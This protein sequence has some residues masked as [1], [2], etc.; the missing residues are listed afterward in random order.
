M[1]ETRYTIDSKDRVRQWQ[2]WA[3]E[4]D[5]IPG[6]LYTDGLVDGKMKDPIF[7]AAKEK[8]V[9]KANYISPAE[10]AVLMV[11]Q[12]V[13]KKERSNYFSTPEEARENKL[14]LPMLCPSGMKWRD[15]A[16]N[17]KKVSWPA[18]ASPKLDGARCNIF[19][20][21]GEVYAQTRTGK[22]WLNCDHI[23]DA[24]RPLLEIHPNW[25]ID[26]E[27]YNHAFKDNFEDLMSIIKKQK[28]TDEQKQFSAVNVQYHIYDI[29]DNNDPECN[30]T[31]RQQ[32]MSWAKEEFDYGRSIVWLFST[33]CLNER[34][35]D[36]FHSKALADGYEGSILRLDAAYDVDKRSKSLLKRK[37]LFDAEFRILDVIEG[38]GTN[39]GIAAKVIIDNLSVD[40]MNKEHLEL[41]TVSTQDAGMAA[42]WNHD[43]CRKLLENKDEVIGQM[44]TIEYFE[45]TGHGVLR[46][47]K[48]KAIRNYE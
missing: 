1:K 11:S 45:V 22:E 39:K 37:E 6:I 27:L 33:V 29:Y 30:A 26:G 21:D 35:F 38:E 24:L 3:G 23:K 31:G 7:K 25:I 32:N 34:N 40:G 17:D 28:P 47:P 14:W 2:C 43:K 20:K 8:N 46:F 9:G 19:M 4:K 5:G 18:Y 44:A 48:M 10:Q 42:G 15:Y 13:G 16:G 36:D 41:M 12:E